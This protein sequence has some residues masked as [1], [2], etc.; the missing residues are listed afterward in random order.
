[1]TAIF[2]CDNC[3]NKEEARLN[4]LGD[5]IKPE[6]WFYERIILWKK[7]VKITEEPKK[8]KG[9]HFCCQNCRENWLRTNLS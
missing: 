6:N 8:N 2:I 1:M 3:K 9:Y 4:Y 5:P 7:E